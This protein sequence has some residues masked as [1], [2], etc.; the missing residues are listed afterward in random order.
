MKLLVMAAGRGT[1]ISRYIEGMPKCTVD[2]GGTRLVEYTIQKFLDMGCVSSI[3]L[4]LGYRSEIL[5]EILSGYPVEFYYNYFYEVTNSIA[6]AWFAKD[7]IDDDMVMMNA[8]VF[9]EEKIFNILLSEKCRE[10]LLLSDSSRKEMADYKFYYEDG[11]LIKYGKELEGDDISGE[12]VGIARLSRDFLPEFKARLH[13][14]VKEGRYNMWWE[15][16]IYSFVGERPVHV[17]DVAGSFWAEVDFIED[18][19]RIL[20]FRKVKK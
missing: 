16:V 6:S 11:Q 3:G 15:D 20:E 14:L 19:E 12:Y 7:F 18:Y 2:I 8:D 17:K 9:A 13:S 5:E 1:R 4:V 10:A